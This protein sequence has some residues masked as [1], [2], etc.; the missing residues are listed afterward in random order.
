MPKAA[1]TAG[2]AATMFAALAISSCGDTVIDD[3]KAEDAIRDNVESSTKV[4]VAAVDCPADVKVEAGRRFECLVT[5]ESGRK[6]TATLKI[7]NSDA[8]VSFV[9]LRP[10]K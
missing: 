7:L 8:D 9:A 10:V 4:K 1:R 3:A 5:A 6:A 2:A